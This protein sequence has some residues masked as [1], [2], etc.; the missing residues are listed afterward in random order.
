MCRWTLQGRWAPPEHP[1]DTSHAFSARCLRLPIRP[2]CVSDTLVGVCVDVCITL[3][4]CRQVCRHVCR[5]VCRQV[6]DTRLGATGA[7]IFLAYHLSFGREGSLRK[8]CE[9]MG[10]KTGGCSYIAAVLILPLPL[11]GRQLARRGITILIMNF[12]HFWVRTF[13]H[14]RQLVYP[15]KR[16]HNGPTGPM[17]PLFQGS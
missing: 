16:R 15:P 13:A 7:A 10:R 12:T 3:C 8:P 1:R 4:T 5:H 9:A 11:A 17:L 2:V 14:G 6:A